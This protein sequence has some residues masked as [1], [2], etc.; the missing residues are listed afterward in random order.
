MVK[1][2]NMKLASNRCLTAVEYCIA[3]KSTENNLSVKMHVEVNLLGLPM[4]KHINMDAHV[5]SAKLLEASTVEGLCSF[6]PT[7]LCPQSVPLLSPSPSV[8]HISPHPSCSPLCPSPGL[9]CHLVGS[10]VSPSCVR[11]CPWARV[12][13]LLGWI[14]L[15]SSLAERAILS[16]RERRSWSALLRLSDFLNICVRRQGL[17]QCVV[18]HCQKA[19]RLK[20]AWAH[21]GVLFHL[22]VSCSWYQSVK[23]IMGRLLSLCD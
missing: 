18:F 16:V 8:P 14:I 9:P 21:N 3:N 15:L 22:R 23:V 13:I 5:A 6:C 4:H 7:F 10:P 17:P 1:I 2:A 12:C 20:A 19:W 11:N